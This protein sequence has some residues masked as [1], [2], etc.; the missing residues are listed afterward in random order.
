MSPMTGLNATVASAMAKPG[1]IAFL[2]QSGALGTAVLDWSL[3]AHIGFSAFVS[4][5]VHILKI[6]DHPF[7]KS[8]TT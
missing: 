4:V 8:L 6:T 5:G 3:R 1:K 7:W 2:S